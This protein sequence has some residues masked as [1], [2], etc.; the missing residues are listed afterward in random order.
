MDLF[1]ALF[2][3]AFM[4][5]FLMTLRDIKEGSNRYATSSFLT[6]L[7]FAGMMYCFMYLLVVSP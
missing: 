7:T 4:V 3:F 6:A 5:F 1:G 2:A